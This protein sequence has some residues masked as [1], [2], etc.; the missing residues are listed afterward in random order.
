[1]MFSTG[2]LVPSVSHLDDYVHG[3]Q[4]QDEFAQTYLTYFLR[5]LFYISSFC[6]E[7]GAE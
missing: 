4:I 7:N 1:M 6:F 3:F 2:P 5:N